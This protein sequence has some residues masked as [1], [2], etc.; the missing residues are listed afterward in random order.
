[1]NSEATARRRYTLASRIV[2]STRAYLRIG[3]V[4]ANLAAIDV[5]GVEAPH[6]S[7]EHEPFAHPLNSEFRN[8]RASEVVVIPENFV[9]QLD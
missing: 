4:F 8:L 7:D 6:L 3:S 2:N 1:M 9:Q 5:G